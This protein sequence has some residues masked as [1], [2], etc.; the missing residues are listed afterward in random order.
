MVQTSL[1]RINVRSPFGTKLAPPIRLADPEA[2]QGV[3]VIGYPAYDSRV[4]HTEVMDRIYGGIY[5]VKRLAPG[6]ILQVDRNRAELPARLYHSRRELRLG[7]SR[8]SHR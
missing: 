8:L 2:G 3:A 5:N 6:R 7:P 4:P 1:L